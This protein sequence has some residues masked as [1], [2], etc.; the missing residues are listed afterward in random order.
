[1]MTRNEFAYKA[2][3]NAKEKGFWKERLSYEHCLMLV[4]TEI[5]EAIEADRKDKHA[6]VDNYQ[7][8]M[9]SRVEVERMYRH[10]T[11]IYRYYQPN[12]VYER[13]L[14]GSIE[15][16]MADIAIRIA[17][18]VGELGRNFD[19]MN[20]GVYDREFDQF[21]FAE[22]AY[23]LTSMLCYSH[24]SF[25]KR[26]FLALDYVFNWA[27]SMNIDLWFFV[28]QKMNYNALRPTLHGKRY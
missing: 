3:K 1:M 18:L 8:C 14:K 19:K 27:K 9:E 16:E 7:F 10:D 13:H 21:T 28:E 22:N 24:F 26:I 2:H 4:I 25:E 11:D 23:A 6:N 5:A 15:D 12:F 17:D 20:F